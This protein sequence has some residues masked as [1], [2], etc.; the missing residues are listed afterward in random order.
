MSISNCCFLTCIQISQEDINFLLFIILTVLGL[1]CGAWAFSVFVAHGLNCPVAHGI[2]VAWPE[3]EPM[4]LHCKAILNCWATRKVPEHIFSI[5]MGICS[6]VELLDYI[7]VYNI[8]RNCQTLFQS[9]CTILQFYQ[10]SSFLTTLQ[11]LVIFLIVAMLVK[12]CEVVLICIT[13]M[14][15]DVE[16][17]FHV[18]IGHLC[19]F[20]GDMS[21]QILCLFLNC[22][23]SFYCW[24]V[25]SSLYFL[26]TRP[27][28]DTYFASIFSHSLVVLSIH[29]Y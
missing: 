3:I 17:H 27:W 8:L 21:V 12:W 25:K 16:L 1:C 26:L 22:Y 19:I 23:R 9:H 11:T 6:G 24:I 14:P 4:S 18:L 2:L 29:L 13:L 20:F 28:P 5:L 10:G 7:I 15:N